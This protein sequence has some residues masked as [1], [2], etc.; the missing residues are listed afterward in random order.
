VGAGPAT[1]GRGVLAL[2]A[3]RGRRLGQ[4]H[5]F[6]GPVTVG[7][8]VLDRDGARGAQSTHDVRNA[9]GRKTGGSCQFR[10]GTSALSPQD[11]DDATLVGLTQCRLR[12]RGRVTPGHHVPLRL[13]LWWNSHAVARNST[14][15][16]HKGKQDPLRLAVG[17]RRCF[18]GTPLLVG[19]PSGTSSPKTFESRPAGQEVHRCTY[20]R[21]DRVGRNRSPT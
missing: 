10:L 2:T 16:E 6:P 19:S 17:T 18:P 15:P 7:R 21:T 20:E 3:H 12:P 4:E 13:V 11:L 14:S 9:G 8:G 5:L 1:V